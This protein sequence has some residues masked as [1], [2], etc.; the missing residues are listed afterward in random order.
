MDITTDLPSRD[1]QAATHRFREFAPFKDF[2]NATFPWLEF[3][4]SWRRDFVADAVGYAGQQHL[5]MQLQ[6]P[7][8]HVQRPRRRAESDQVGHI[9]FF[10]QLSGMT[11]LEQGGQEV[12]MRPGDTTV[13]DTARAYRL[14]VADHARF[15]VLLLPY[16]SYPDWFRT[17]E[18]LVATRLTERATTRAAL[19][20]LMSLMQSTAAGDDDC[21]EDVVLPVQ[22]MLC[23]SLER[24][25]GRPRYGAPE[26]RSLLQRVQAHIDRN[27][28]DPGLSPG[29]LARA[30][31]LSRRGLYLA[32]KRH[33]LTPARLITDTRLARCRQAL[34]DPARQARTI[35]DIAFEYGFADAAR[36]SH[37]FRA[38]H[39]MPPREWRHRVLADEQ[40]NVAGRDVVAPGGNAMRTAG[41]AGTAAF[42]TTVFTRRE[43]QILTQLP[44]C[45]SNADVA[46]SLSVSENTVKFHLK[47]IYRKLGVSGR[48]PAIRAAGAL[49]LLDFSQ[50]PMHARSE[51]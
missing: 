50:T 37:I 47:S 48:L 16:D 26:G 44:E 21:V 17:A 30:V 14:R 4:T 46:R 49:G 28:H 22:S 19:C 1:F 33:G 20:A 5:I 6:T 13:C 43:R 38:C 31:N 8:V 34:A 45:G 29:E 39:G 40:F 23:N 25:A 32:L 18:R 42:S 2:V 12:V 15:A 11:A 7:A 41:S 36:F 24:M 10:W 9:K 27:L 3:K 51:L 35:T